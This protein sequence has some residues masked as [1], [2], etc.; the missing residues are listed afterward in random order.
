VCPLGLLAGSWQ[1]LSASPNEGVQA[2]AY[3]LRSA[4]AFSR[5]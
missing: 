5:A 3:N 2:T 4:A 1:S